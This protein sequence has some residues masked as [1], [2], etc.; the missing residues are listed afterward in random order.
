MDMASS[1]K[2][3]LYIDNE[4]FMEGKNRISAKISLPRGW[5]KLRMVAVGGK[6]E[7]G[8]ETTILSL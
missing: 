8:D 3:F 4:A 5:H 1:E 6:E 7:A 2:L